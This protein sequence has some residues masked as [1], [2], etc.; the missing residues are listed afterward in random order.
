M[1]VK[2]FRDE[3]AVDL[4]ESVLEISLDHIVVTNA[5][6]LVVDS[7]LSVSQNWFNTARLANTEL[8]LAECAK[9]CW[10]P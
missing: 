5:R 2:S 9:P 7:A 3:L 10:L 6:E 4:V 1:L 8:S